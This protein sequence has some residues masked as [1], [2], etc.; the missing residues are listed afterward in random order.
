MLVICPSE[1]GVYE[2]SAGCRPAIATAPIARATTVNTSARRG[3]RR[4]KRPLMRNLLGRT[5]TPLA[6][7]VFHP[8]ESRAPD[9]CG[10]LDGLG[11][12]RRLRVTRVVFDERGL[13]AGGRG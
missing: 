4:R 5:P 7:A 12:G 9:C 6:G 3:D 13:D 2:R 10:A 1:L 8:A 11:C